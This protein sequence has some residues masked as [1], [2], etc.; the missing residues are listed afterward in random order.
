M[1]PESAHVHL[2]SDNCHWSILSSHDQVHFI[3]HAHGL[4]AAS[5]RDLLHAWPPPRTNRLTWGSA[6]VG[7]S[8]RF[9]DLQVRQGSL[10][11]G[12]GELPIEVGFASN[13]LLGA[14]DRLAFVQALWPNN[15]FGPL[16]K[17]LSE[18]DGLPT[19]VRIYK[20]MAGHEL[21]AEWYLLDI[22]EVALPSGVFEAP[23]QYQAPS[24]E[25]TRVRHAMTPR[26]GGGRFDNRP[27]GVHLPSGPP[28]DAGI[29]FAPSFYGK[30]VAIASSVAQVLTPLVDQPM[31]FKIDWAAELLARFKRVGLIDVDGLMTLAVAAVDVQLREKVAAAQGANDLSDLLPLLTPVQRA[32]LLGQ[33]VEAT[34]NARW[35]GFADLDQRQTIDTA[36]LNQVLLKPY[37]VTIVDSSRPQNLIDALADNGIRDVTVAFDQDENGVVVKIGG[38]LGILDLTL[39]KL[40][41]ELQLQDPAVTGGD[42]GNLG[43]GLSLRSH[44]LQLQFEFETQL[45]IDSLVAIAAAL[46]TFG[47]AGAA[48]LNAGVGDVSVGDAMFSGTLTPLP[49]NRTLTQ[50]FQ[51][52]PVP[53]HVDVN[54]FAIG[55]NPLQDIIFLVTA[56]AIS[57]FDIFADDIRSQV[58]ARVNKSL[59]DARALE[60]PFTFTAGGPSPAD[61]PHCDPA[62]VVLANPVLVE[63]IITSAAS[64][65]HRGVYGHGLA[66]SIDSKPFDPDLPLDGAYVF[67]RQ[68]LASCI[69]RRLA[70]ASIAI[71]PG[72]AAP[73]GAPF[74]DAFPPDVRTAEVFNQALVERLFALGFMTSTEREEWIGLLHLL[75]N[76]GVIGQDVSLQVNTP[77]NVTASG[78]PRAALDVSAEVEWSDGWDG[79]PVD[80]NGLPGAFAAARL[81]IKVRHTVD[82]VYRVAQGGTELLSFFRHLIASAA[83]NSQNFRPTL[84]S[85]LAAAPVFDATLNRRG[86]LRVGL[87]KQ[88]EDPIPGLPASF[89]FS[90]SEFDALPD[91]D[92][93]RLTD[94]PALTSDDRVRQL[95]ATVAAVIDTSGDD[96]GVLDQRLGRPLSMKGRYLSFLSLRDEQVGAHWFVTNPAGDKEALRTR[97]D[98]LYL[99]FWIDP[100]IIRNLTL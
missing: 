25:R 6:A 93:V 41:L 76:A 55:L 82:L 95:L 52:N 50:A 49:G 9:G 86:S 48:L 91:G 60:F 14:G 32:E 35:N 62:T 53:G 26:N 11:Y 85:R 24:G 30:G 16:A 92:V 1:A 31:Q 84:P 65:Y 5:A 97:G 80:D 43:V 98:R 72:L 79:V 12:A 47:L 39:S 64:I 74:I 89:E 77:P 36:Y 29:A 100:L 2:H 15:V 96:E 87:W 4:I 56:A 3:D 70:A 13:E 94:I 61:N 73:E 37:D 63:A 44:F 58:A 68:V 81:A 38:M 45:G 18:V 83:A 20:P 33:L 57:L 10:D 28:I 7:D 19:Q 17:E 54:A 46:V 59:A 51:L 88:D 40:R 69:E 75:Q 27:E 66:E 99:D 8:D 90:V 78:I 67:H 21:L 34:G 42:I 22:A 23:L 71:N